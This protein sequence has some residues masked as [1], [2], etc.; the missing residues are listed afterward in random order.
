MAHDSWKS[1]KRERTFLGFDCMGMFDPDKVTE[2]LKYV[3]RL[4]NMLM[5]LFFL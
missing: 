2:R 4:L 5:N 3:R 1:D